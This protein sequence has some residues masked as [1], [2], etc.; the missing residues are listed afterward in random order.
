MVYESRNVERFIPTDEFHWSLRS[1][2]VAYGE[3]AQAVQRPLVVTHLREV[4][5]YRQMLCIPT[6][7]PTND[8]L[9]WIMP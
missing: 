7:L 5:A 8:A 3:Y 9:K 1:L 6:E 4:L 2:K